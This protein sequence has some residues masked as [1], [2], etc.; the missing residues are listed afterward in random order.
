MGSGGRLLA[1]CDV[2]RLGDV[3]APLRTCPDTSRRRTTAHSLLIGPYSLHLI[4]YFSLAKE[5]SRE[6]MNGCAWRGRKEVARVVTTNGS[7]RGRGLM[8]SFTVD[9]G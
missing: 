5:G 7:R 3:R 1:V 8:A 6:M 4:K 2:P 9:C